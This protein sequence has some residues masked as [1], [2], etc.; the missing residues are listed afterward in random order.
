MKGMSSE[1]TLVSWYTS[2]WWYTH[3]HKTNKMEW[4][5][6]SHH[7]HNRQT[8]DIL[9]ENQSIHLF[10]ANEM[11]NVLRYERIS[12][13]INE[14]NAS[15]STFQYSHVSSINLWLWLMY[16]HVRPSYVHCTIAPGFRFWMESII[17]INE[18]RMTIMEHPEICSYEWLK[19]NRRQKKSDDENK[20]E[21]KSPNI[22]NHLPLKMNGNERISAYPIKSKFEINLLLMYDCTCINF[23][24][25]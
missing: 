20:T 8:D 11:V 4:V 2:D 21:I 25:N 10:A 9:G 7:N 18:M 15:E 16:F 1:L 24:A 13:T 14:L 23:I 12:K 22:V 17:L 5:S 19:M 6:V 3:T